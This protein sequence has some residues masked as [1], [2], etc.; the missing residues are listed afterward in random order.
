MN[1]G[2]RVGLLILGLGPLPALGL[3]IHAQQGASTAADLAAA[4]QEHNPEGLG[5][6]A[7]LTEAGYQ[8]VG[9]LVDDEEMSHFIK[10]IAHIMGLRIV[11]T[12]GLNGFVPH[13][14][15][16][17]ALQDLERLKFELANAPW[18]VNLLTTTLPPTT[19]LPS[20]PDSWA[21]ATRLVMN[22]VQQATEMAVVRERE[23]ART[24][25][26]N[27]R[28]FTAPDHLEG[29]ASRV[30]DKAVP[31]VRAAL[32]T[33]DHEEDEEDAKIHGPCDNDA[34]QNQILGAYDV[35]KEAPPRLSL[36]FV[37]VEEPEMI[38]PTTTTAQATDWLKSFYSDECK[39]R[40]SQEYPT[41]EEDMCKTKWPMIWS[42]QY[43]LAYHK[44]PQSGSK[45]FES[46]F[47]QHF[48]D[49]RF[50]Q[51]GSALPE[52]TFVFTFVRDPMARAISS[53]ARMS[54]Q[55]AQ[56]PTEKTNTTFQ[57]VC[58][59]SRN[60]NS[61]FHTYLQDVK[62]GRFRNPS[63]LGTDHTMS[64]VAGIMWCTQAQY[65]H[66]VGHLEN[67]EEDWRQIQTLA[68]LPVQQW[69]MAS[70]Q[71]ADVDLKRH[72]LHAFDTDFPPNR[73]SLREMCSVYTVDFTCLGYAPPKVCRNLL[74]TS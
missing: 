62:Q 74:K 19:P 6:R 46:F 53:Y 71:A 43:K 10:R 66:Y 29:S 38:S 17:V 26:Y 54:L 18:V 64:Q 20:N 51:P 25:L 61:R 40:I 49:A 55:A 23:H 68:K 32:E 70:G 11:D 41:Q 27:G 73:G 28:R 8:A 9:D 63:A 1:P 59:S 7:P 16:T 35:H 3:G 48:S 2:F 31:E 39:A 4:L 12:G 65:L 72:P 21:P 44:M 50:L 34:E 14:S 30:A 67:V 60:G 24:V 56:H 69:T 42:P 58:R 36:S 22:Y 57:S 45:D 37:P 13:Y 33:D 5:R 15:G 52:D 47:L